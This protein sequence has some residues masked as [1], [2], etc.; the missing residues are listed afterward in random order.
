MGL[1][2]V[3]LWKLVHEPVGLG[4]VAGRRSVRITTGGRRWWASSDGVPGLGV[5]VGFGFG[6]GHVG[7]VPLAPLEVFH[8]WYGAGAVAAGR[9][10]VGNVGVANAF[11]NARV[12]GASQ[13]HARHRFRPCGAVSGAGMVRPSGAELARA[14]AIRG[15]L[16]GIQPTAAS[17]RDVGRGGQFARDA[18][19]Q[20]QHAVLQPRRGGSE[21]VAKRASGAAPAWRSLNGIQSGQAAAGATAARR[22]RRSRRLPSNYRYNGGSQQGAYATAEPDASRSNSRCG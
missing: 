8:P 20:L 2:S 16:A 6:F 10:G 4:L 11:R 12:N 9:L 15:A 14:S 3:S 13:Q 19:D 18:A 5:G 17:R 22:G 7:W 1:G 21:R